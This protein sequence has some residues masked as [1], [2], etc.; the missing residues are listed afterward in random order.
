VSTKE[1]RITILNAAERPLK[2]WFSHLTHAVL[3]PEFNM[4]GC[5]R[6]PNWSP[7]DRQCVAPAHRA[8]HEVARKFVIH[9]LLDARQM[10]RVPTTR[11]VGSRRVA[12]LDRAQTYGALIRLSVVAVAV[13]HDPALR[14]DATRV[15]LMQVAHH[16]TVAAAVPQIDR[17][18]RWCHADC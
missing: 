16:H 4:L 1:C 18:R 6:V 11:Q 10:G 12:L 7:V 14:R 9:Q 13:V 8:A 2:E 3:A 17:R 5:R 15:V